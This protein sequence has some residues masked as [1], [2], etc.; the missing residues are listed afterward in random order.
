M[1]EIRGGLNNGPP[2]AKPQKP[3][4]LR[5]DGTPETFNPNQ[6]GNIAFT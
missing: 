5:S 4:R 2:P 1:E 3:Q 6:N